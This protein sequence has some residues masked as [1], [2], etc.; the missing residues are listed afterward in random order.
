MIPTPEYRAAWSR[1]AGF[2]A[3]KEEAYPGHTSAQEFELHRGKRVLEYGCGGGADAMSYLR[4]GCTVWFVDIVEENVKA[5]DARIRAAGLGA[6]GQ[7]WWLEHNDGIPLPDGVAD[8]ASAH[9]VIHHIPEPVPVLQEIRRVLKPGGLFYCMLYTEFL[10]ARAQPVIR[11]LTENGRCTVEEAFCAFTDGPG[12]PY[13]RAYTD[14]DA[15]HLF[16]SAGFGAV[17]VTGVYNRGDFR[18]Y[19]AVAP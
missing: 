16:A 10:L 11:D 3:S 15:R 9:G 7:G 18:T 17:D 4:R 14:D 12:A 8:V 2:P 19:R 5:A 13:A 6:M 1:A